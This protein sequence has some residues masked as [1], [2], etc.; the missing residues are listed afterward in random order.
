MAH[1][2]PPSPS[3]SGVPRSFPKTFPNS[4]FQKKRWFSPNSE[5][6][7][8]SLPPLDP[9]LCHRPLPKDAGV[10]PPGSKMPVIASFFGTFLPIKNASTIDLLQ[11][12]SK[13]AKVG[14]K[15]AQGELL[16]QFSLPFWLPFW[17]LFR[18]FS[19][20]LCFSIERTAPT[21]ERLF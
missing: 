8:P 10:F 3:G 17:S 13:C 18:T 20:T 2:D 14:P 15:S 19:R 11:R 4:K 5:G 16:A 12:P 21:R 1:L 9:R 6:L 7:V